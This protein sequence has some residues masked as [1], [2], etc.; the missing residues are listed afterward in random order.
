MGGDFSCMCDIDAQGNIMEKVKGEVKLK[1]CLEN[2][3]QEDK[4]KQ[5]KK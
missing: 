4:R 5:D 1:V 2:K 3:P